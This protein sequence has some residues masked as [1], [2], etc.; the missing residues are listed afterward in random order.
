MTVL[1]T[2]NSFRGHWFGA[3]EGFL[4]GSN[5]FNMRQ[6]VRK[7]ETGQNFEI[8]GII[9][10]VDTSYSEITKIFPATTPGLLFILV[11]DRYSNFYLLKSA[12]GGLT[13]HKVFTFG[14]GN[15]INQCNT[16]NVRLL[17]GILELTRDLPAGGGKGDLYF[18]EYNINRNRIPGSTNDRLRIMK[19][20]DNGETWIKIMEW[21]TN[22]YNQ[23]GHIHAMKQDPY[24]GEIYV[25]TGD[26]LNKAGII[27]WNG[28][29]PWR[30]NATL[31]GLKTLTGFSVLTGGQRFRAVDMLFDQN[32]FYTVTDT[33][34]PNNLDGSESG[35]WKGSKDLSSYRRVNNHIYNY[36]P[37]HIGWF[38]EKLGNT[39]IFTTSR[40]IES[41]YKWKKLNLQVYTSTDGEN[42]Y[43]TG[44]LNMRDV[45][46]DT[47]TKYIAN[48]FVLNNKIYIDCVGGSGHYSTIQ[49]ELSRKW[50]VNDDPVILHPVFFV[51]KWNVPGN[52][53]YSGTSPDSPKATLKNILEGSKI[54]AGG[55]VRISS[56]T[57]QEGYI[58]PDWSSTFVQG[59]GSVLIEGKGMDSTFIIR[60][61]G[62]GEASGM[63]IEQLKTRS[64][65]NSP[66]IFKDLSYSNVVDGGTAH[67]S[68]V[69]DNLDT[70]VKTMGCRLGGVQNDD[71][72]LVSLSGEGAGYISDSTWYISPSFQSAWK[73]S[74]VSNAVNQFIDIK[75]SILL[76]AYDALAIN[77]TGASLSLKNCTFYGTGRYGVSFNATTTIQPAILNCIFSGAD[78]PINDL[79]GI[80]ETNVDYNYYEKPNVNV[81]GGANSINS[82]GKRIFVDT[83]KG[84]FELLSNSPVSMGGKYLP[85]VAYDIRGRIR[86]KPPSIGAYESPALI[87][88]PSSLELNHLAGGCGNIQVLSKSAW[89]ISWGADWISIP[90]NTGSGNDTI[91]VTS[92]SSNSEAEKRSCSIIFSGAGLISDTVMVI[93]SATDATDSIDATDSPVVEASMMKVYPNPVSDNL[94]I[95][96]GGAVYDSFSII[97]SMGVMLK[98]EEVT[99]PVQQVDLSNFADGIYFIRFTGRGV[100]VLKVQVIHH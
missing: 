77:F 15:G 46:P 48:I 73:S 81:N 16:P 92:L 8:R 76:N 56:G 75:N 54:P 14:E 52:D 42:W 66:I 65:K 80:I 27:K 74:V 29:S 89:S 72:P 45:S 6:I 59:S 83:E 100:K 9:T 78:A 43:V 35:I 64:G 31:P 32:S 95:E 28:V 40:E 60:S 36:D 10:S 88:I 24:T 41:T 4:Y 70:Y 51:G 87:V 22:G 99:F 17:R 90:K 96:Y 18:G 85:E 38:G 55:R 19:S 12:D 91:V 63:K 58:N 61:P 13:M 50:M 2:V 62:V 30:D 26:N 25:C 57:F 34:K 21:N 82:S 98:K 79:S 1:E 53:A 5:Y 3:N 84:N 97:N 7:G 47:T 68:Y 33:Q 67:I 94:R 69:I 49:C 44:Q 11:Q 23:V 71:S 86:A 93:Q 20:T 39:F 37:M